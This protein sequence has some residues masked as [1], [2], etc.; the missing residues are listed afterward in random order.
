MSFRRTPSAAL[1]LHRRADRRLD[2]NRFLAPGVVAGVTYLSDAGLEYAAQES[3][4]HLATVSSRS[5]KRSIFR[6]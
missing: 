4:S 2:G 1:D 3:A 5:S 6:R